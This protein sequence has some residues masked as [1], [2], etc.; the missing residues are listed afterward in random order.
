MKKRL[1]SLALALALCMG[2]AVSASAAEGGSQ[3][4]SDSYEVFDQTV[5]GDW[6]MAA[7][8]PRNY[9]LKDK[10]GNIVIPAKYTEMFLFQN[11]IFVG[12]GNHSMVG[13]ANVKWGV[14]DIAQTVIVPLEYDSI[15]PLG[16]VTYD[17]NTHVYDPDGFIGCY[18]IR[19][20]DLVG[21]ASENFSVMI[22][23]AYRYIEY[24][25][26]GYFKFSNT[27]KPY[28]YRLLGKQAASM[29]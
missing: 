1:F 5:P 10:A 6:S 16:P 27:D 9:G 2:L 23:P 4:L 22:K 19:K 3:N 21:V 28:D 11:L 17:R 18:S 7:M 29:G 25:K 13:P 26:L 14:I 12:M 20:N 15:R 24:D 8:I